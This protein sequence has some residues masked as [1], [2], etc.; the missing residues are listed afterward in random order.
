MHSVLEMQRT[1]AYIVNMNE[2]IFT[3]NA[4]KRI[5]AIKTAEK[6]Y[7]RVEVEGGG[8]QGFSYKMDLEDTI[9]EDDVVIT[10]NGETLVIDPDSAEIMAGSTVDFVEELVGAAFKVTNPQ[11][12]SSCGCGVSFSL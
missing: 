6:P 11:A 7:F 3:E 5:A 4:A 9:A 8:C 1:K 10:T 12:A 2:I